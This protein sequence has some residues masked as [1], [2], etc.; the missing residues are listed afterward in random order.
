MIEKPFIRPVIKGQVTRSLLSFSLKSCARSRRHGEDE[1]MKNTTR[2][3]E[4]WP[5]YRCFMFWDVWR[6]FSTKKL[7]CSIMYV[8]WNSSNILQGFYCSSMDVFLQT[9]RRN[10]KRHLFA[11]EGSSSLLIKFNKQTCFEQKTFIYKVET[12]PVVSTVITPLYMS[13]I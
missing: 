1:V 8:S 13:Y 7:T 5:V 9:H 2:G 3:W 10:D 12:L 6:G 11:Q 4:E